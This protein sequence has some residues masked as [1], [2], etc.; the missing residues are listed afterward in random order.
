MEGT[1]RDDEAR[2]SKRRC[3]EPVVAKPQPIIDS[4]A[5]KPVKLKKRAFL[6]KGYAVIRNL[7]DADQIAALITSAKD[8]L[9]NQNLRDQY[10]QKNDPKRYEYIF[11]PELETLALLNDMVKSLASKLELS[12]KFCIVSE[13]GSQDQPWHTD[14]IPGPGSGLA[15]VDWRDTLH[16]IGVLTPLVETNTE[17]GMTDVKLASHVNTGSTSKCN[18]VTVSLKPGDVLMMDGR[19]LHRGLQ[20]NSEATVRTM[21]F[22]TYKL[23]NFEDGNAEAYIK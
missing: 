20:N 10:N 6:A 17:C 4:L 12:Q 19:T 1:T 22:F 14:S 21:C 23:S 7:F 18:V 9:P 16:Y 2:S 5:R 8:K 11:A 15:D 3:V 13:P